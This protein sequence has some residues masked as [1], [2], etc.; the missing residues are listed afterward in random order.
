MGQI[1]TEL[2]MRG[3]PLQPAHFADEGSAFTRSADFGLAVGASRAISGTP[4]Y[5]GNATHLETRPRGDAPGWP[6]GAQYRVTV[7]GREMYTAAVD[8]AAGPGPARIPGIGPNATGRLVDPATGISADLHG[9]SA[10]YHDPSGALIHARDLPPDV[11]T[12][13]GIAENGGGLPGGPL[14]AD[15]AG[16]LTDPR[17]VH[18]ASGVSV[19]TSTGRLFDE[20]GRP[21][22]YASVRPD[23]RR[24]LGFAEDG[25]FTDPRFIADPSGYSVHPVTGEIVR[26]AD[27]APVDPAGLDPEVRR[28]LDAAAQ[29]GRVQFGGHNLDG[30]YRPGDRVLVY[31]AGASGAWDV[32]QAAMRGR[33][34]DWAARDELGAPPHSPEE[35][36]KAFQ[37]A[38][39]YNR[40]NSAEHGAFSEEV[41][42]RVGRS[43]RSPVEVLPTTDGRLR[44]T[45]SD[46]EVEVYDRVV[47]SIGQESTYPGGPADLVAG[48]SLEPL[49]GTGSEVNGLRDPTGTLR[50]LG[51]ASVTAGAVRSLPEHLRGTV[52]ALTADQASVLPQDSRG[53]QPSIRHHAGRIAEANIPLDSFHPGVTD[54]AGHLA[55]QRDM[56]FA[57]VAEHLAQGG[58]SVRGIPGPESVPGMALLR[59]S[60]DDPGTVAVLRE[61]ALRVPERLSRR[62]ELELDRLSATDARELVVDGRAAGLTRAEAIAVR[63]SVKDRLRDITLRFL[64]AGGET[65]T[66]N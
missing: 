33:H 27:H 54:P 48:H 51:Y 61:T 12:R 35:I 34:V 16:R 49:Y 50:V 1:P 52:S 28:A 23:V 53:I 38:G 4:T 3:L 5:L 15:G 46:G 42:N 11:R 9:G 25:S 63:D 13:F 45:F 21:V 26:T 36:D 24:A 8:V 30:D 40:R 55:K 43:L 17:V 10:T 62:V 37:D 56:S 59:A 19:D 60:A 6:A 2:E 20:H 65:L 22:E 64:L 44:V 57:R 47:I 31:G 14:L 66:G 39:G 58:L 18:E 29:R 32:E 7:D 41:W